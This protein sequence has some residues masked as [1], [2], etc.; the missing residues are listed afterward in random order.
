MVFFI[1][2]ICLHSSHV[3][4]MMNIVLYKLW[5]GWAFLALECSLNYVQWAPCVVLGVDHTSP[6]VDQKL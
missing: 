1:E 4:I 6:W 3:G 2:S 5:N